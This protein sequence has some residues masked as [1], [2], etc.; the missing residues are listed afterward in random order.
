[1]PLRRL[2]RN[3]RSPDGTSRPATKNCCACERL[4]GM[5]ERYAV[6]SVAP[7]ADGGSKRRTSAAWASKWDSFR[8]P[9]T[10]PFHFLTAVSLSLG[11]LVL[12]DAGLCSAASSRYPSGG[13]IGAIIR[14]CIEGNRRA[15][16]S[17]TNSV[18]DD[19]E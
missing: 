14:P 7:L 11:A 8:M 6:M 15:W 1:V 12:L 17:L 5:R 18:D 16:G 13:G 3:G 9:R 4:T 2:P 10:G 19:F